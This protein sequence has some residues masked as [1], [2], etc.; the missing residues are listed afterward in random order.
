MARKY[1]RAFRNFLRDLE[2]TS[3]NEGIMLSLVFFLVPATRTDGA[4]V[5]S[6]HY[7]LFLNF[8]S[9]DSCDDE[10]NSGGECRYAGSAWKLGQQTTTCCVR[11]QEFG[12]SSIRTT[13][14]ARTGLQ[15]LTEVRTTLRETVRA[16][17]SF[18]N[19][20]P[21]DVAYWVQTIQYKYSQNMLFVHG[22]NLPIL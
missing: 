19:S 8:E 21:T 13:V 7:I 5:G 12:G 11:T 1:V 16:V 15:I 20:R 3:S 18:Q 10:T 22:I 14:V 2:I 9:V 4:P 17:N 6:L